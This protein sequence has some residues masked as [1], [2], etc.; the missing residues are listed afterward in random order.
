MG[1]PTDP[2]RQT[3]RDLVRA[4]DD[5][6]DNADRRFDRAHRHRLGRSGFISRFGVPL[7]RAR[8]AYCEVAMASAD[9]FHHHLATLVE[10]ALWPYFMWTTT[11]G[12]VRSILGNWLREEPRVETLPAEPWVTQSSAVLKFATALR[13]TGYTATLSLE[14]QRE[15]PNPLTLRLDVG[16]DVSMASVRW[17]RERVTSSTSTDLIWKRDRIWVIVDGPRLRQGDRL[18]ITITSAKPMAQS[19]RVRIGDTADHHR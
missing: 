19:I 13:A 3:A 6:A 18:D 10:S 4:F 8:T 1:P 2:L 15:L 14:A 9:P 11:D 5:F 12:P 16:T 7:A 17:V